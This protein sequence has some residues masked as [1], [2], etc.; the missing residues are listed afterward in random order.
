MYYFNGGI[1]KKNNMFEMV[2]QSN[3][4]P[5]V[6]DQE[7]EIMKTTCRTSVYKTSEG[8]SKA[9]LIKDNGVVPSPKKVKLPYKLQGELFQAAL[10]F[11]IK[12]AF[13][14]INTSPLN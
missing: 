5:Y 3:G 9:T 6:T 14:N 13:Q 1:S 10:E 7:S 11:E 12:K 8:F 4:L 2:R